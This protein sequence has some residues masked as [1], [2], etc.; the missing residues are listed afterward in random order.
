MFVPTLFG[1]LI[2]LWHAFSGLQD[3]QAA[4]KIDP[5]NEVL[6]AD[7]QRIRDIIQGTAVQPET[8]WHRKWTVLLVCVICPLPDRIIHDKKELKA[9]VYLWPHSHTA[10]FCG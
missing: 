4:L 8:Q 1:Q 5:H 2:D 9:A 6:Q 7:T 3:Y 10:P